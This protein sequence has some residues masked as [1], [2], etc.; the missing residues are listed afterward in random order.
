MNPT[1]RHSTLTIPPAFD[2]SATR[3]VRSI[4]NAS[5]R[6]LFDTVDAGVAMGQCLIQLSHE[7]VPHAWPMLVSFLGRREPSDT[8]AYEDTTRKPGKMT[9]RDLWDRL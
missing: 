7:L 3:C 1:S 4:R 8:S 6:I 9:V 2:Q 5:T